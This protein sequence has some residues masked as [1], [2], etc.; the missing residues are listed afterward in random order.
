MQTQTER[1]GV[2]KLDHYFSSHGWLFREQMVHDFG[3]DAHVE[4]TNENYPTGQLIAIQ[5]KSGMSFFSEKN[6]DSYIFR[7]EDKHIKYWSNHT[8]PVILVLYNTDDEILY[9]QDVNERTV[10]STGKGWKI[11][12]PK[13]QILDDR[14]LIMLSRLTQPE[15][16]IQ[17]LNKLKLDRY[18]MEKINDG[19]EV[20][21]EFDDW[22][23]KSLSRYQISLS[24][25]DDSQHWPVT[26]C[27]GMSIEEALDFFLPWADFQMDIEA[28]REGSI[29]QWDADCYIAY[30]KEEGRAI[31]GMS[32]E[33]WYNEPEEIV[34]YQEDGEVAT[35][36]LQLELNDLG[37]SFMEIDGF[38]TNK[39]K[40]QGRT[41]T[42]DDLQ[43]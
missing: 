38:L 9:W 24:C 42:T 1:L 30:D 40:F 18:W 21:V 32:F 12:V 2:S 22:I 15:P 17:K 14:S 11:E 37:R 39:N 35:Y 7:T 8:L 10:V 6:D 23:N 19:D 3:I 27:P 33:E 16:Y 41:F 25:H 29:G 5:I 28:H 43:W 26:Y 4:T 31:H 34:P 20:F 13:K 36:R